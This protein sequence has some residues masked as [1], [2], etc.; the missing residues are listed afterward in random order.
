MSENG[1]IVLPVKER[2]HHHKKYEVIDELNILSNS[3]WKRIHSKEVRA[4]FKKVIR[5]VNAL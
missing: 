2:A 5:L 1:K 3:V 4:Q